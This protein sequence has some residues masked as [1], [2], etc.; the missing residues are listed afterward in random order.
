MQQQYK[1]QQQQRQRQRQQRDLLLDRHHASIVQQ[2]TSSGDH[3]LCRLQCFR[4]I[5]VQV[6]QGAKDPRHKHWSGESAV[7]LEMD[8][9]SKRLLR[10]VSA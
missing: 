3:K 8:P 7:L 4:Q 10:Y 5:G 9:S 2:A 1:L 6:M